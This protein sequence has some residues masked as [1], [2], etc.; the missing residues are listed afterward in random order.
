MKFYIYIIINKINNK[1]YIGKTTNS[2]YE[3]FR[4][5]LN[6]AIKCRLD[7]PLAHAIRKYGSNNFYVEL[8]DV[9]SSQE[10]LN[11]KEVYWIKFLNAIQD[12]YNASTG[13]EGGNTYARKSEFEL[14]EIKAKIRETKMGEKNPHSALVKCKNVITGQELTFPTIASCKAYFN[15]KN[16]NF[17][18]RRCSG[19]TKYVYKGEWIFAYRNN[20]YI[21]DYHF[22]KDI[23]RR[24]AVKIVNITTGDENIFSSYAKAELH[25]GLKRG[26]FSGDA[27]K[28]KNKPYWEKA[29]YRIFVLE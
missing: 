13:G 9:A 8:L 20:E 1:F 10:E 26:F 28:H 16:H 4:Q 12:G 6:D 18:T 21:N 15:E 24:K 7:T 5:H 14:S 27:Y 3:R 25:F 23:C 17:I 22:E 19:K 29:G 11:Q 2:I